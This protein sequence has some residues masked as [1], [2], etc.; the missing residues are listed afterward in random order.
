MNHQPLKV[1]YT[2]STPVAGFSH[3]MHLDSL[4]AF[5][6]VEFALRQP[7]LDRLRPKIELVNEVCAKLPIAIEHRDGKF[8]YQAS[9]LRPVKVG[10]HQARMFTRVTDTEHMCHQVEKGDLTGLTKHEIG[11]FGKLINIS[12]GPHKN[13]L[14]YYPTRMVS[15]FEGF[16]VGDLDQL[17]SYLNPS[18][19]FIQYLGAKRRL[20]HGKISDFKIEVCAEASVRWKERIVPWAEA[21][22]IPIQSRVFPP[23]TELVHRQVAYAHPNIFA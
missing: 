5:A 22:R 15:E 16:L 9:V 19:G 1:I 21:G 20:G 12:S 2:V 17:D 8:C 3:P 7:G 18:S 11:P 23:Y 14:E 4:V 13:T 6:A 10:T